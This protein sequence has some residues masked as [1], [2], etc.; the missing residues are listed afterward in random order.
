MSHSIIFETKFVKLS[1]GR[2]LHLDRSGCNNDTSGRSL[3]DFIGK[4]YTNEK[5]RDYTESF[6]K[7]GKPSK[8]YRGELKIGNRYCSYYD[9]GEHLLRMSKRA[10]SYDDFCSE[11]RFRANRYDGVELYEPE[12]KTLTPKEFENYFYDSIYSGKRISYRRILTTLNNET[13][14]IKSLENNQPVEFYVGKKYKNNN[15]IKD[16]FR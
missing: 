5:L 11:R 3:S 13:E 4:I 8:E 12:R 10:I 16:G 1:D 15:Y 14:I 7:G 6:M 9:Y 2:L